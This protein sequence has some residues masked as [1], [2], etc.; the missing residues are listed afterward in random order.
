[1]RIHVLRVTYY[2]KVHATDLIRACPSF[3]PHEEHDIGTRLFRPRNDRKSRHPQP[4][5]VSKQGEP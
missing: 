3:M 5:D 4:H 1:M 2:K